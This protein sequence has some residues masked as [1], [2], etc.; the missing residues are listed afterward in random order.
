MAYLTVLGALHFIMHWT[1]SSSQSFWSPQNAG[2]HLSW[3]D[4]GILL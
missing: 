2:M 1:R 3:S 4:L